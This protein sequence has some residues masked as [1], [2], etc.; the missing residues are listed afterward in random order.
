MNITISTDKAK[1]DISLIHTFLTTSYW[2]EGRTL[3]TIAS[4]I[5]VLPCFD[6]GVPL[7]FAILE[8]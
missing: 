8:N 6:K 2:A 5:E 4:S 1:L 3:E 7:L